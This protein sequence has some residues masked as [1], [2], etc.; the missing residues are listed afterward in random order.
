ML[1]KI[2]HGLAEI[3]QTFGSINDPKFEAKNIVLFDLPY[4]LLYDRA[5]VVRARC[6]R[7]VVENFVRAFT[8]VLAAGMA[9]RFSE[10]NGIYAHRPIRGR[11]N[12][13]THSWGIAIDMCASQFPLGSAARFP[14]AIV[15]AF[16]D[17]GFFYGG[18]FHGRRDPMHFQLATGY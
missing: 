6:H 2:P 12:P 17:A 14:D 8:G 18:D 1:T 3:E 5:T 4:P 10:F 15:K 11:S 7:L 13:S 9:D 16:N